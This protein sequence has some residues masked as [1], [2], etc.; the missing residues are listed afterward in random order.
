MLEVRFAA[1]Y[2]KYVLILAVVEL[3]RLRFDFVLSDGCNGGN[4]SID[5]DGLKGVSTLVCVITVGQL[6]YEHASVAARDVSSFVDNQ[7]IF[8]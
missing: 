1:I 5:L 2:G 8:V 3:M 6:D 7:V 4:D